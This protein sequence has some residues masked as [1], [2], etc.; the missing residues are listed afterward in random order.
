MT[1]RGASYR[2]Q[3]LSGNSRAKIRD[4]CAYRDIHKD[5]RLY[6]RQYGHRTGLQTLTYPLEITVDYVKGVEKVNAR[7][8]IG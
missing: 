8:D 5:I 2:I 6:T 1:P 3:V 7:S 4:S